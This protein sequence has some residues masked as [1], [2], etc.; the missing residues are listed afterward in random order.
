[1]QDKKEDKPLRQNP[2]ILKPGKS[3]ILKDKRKKK[4]K[5]QLIEELE[6]AHIEKIDNRPM[7]I[8]L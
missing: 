3:L 7:K 2:K 6:E 5:L 8:N 4:A 1:M